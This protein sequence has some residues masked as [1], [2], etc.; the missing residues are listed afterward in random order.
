MPFNDFDVFYRA[1]QAVMN[2][3]DPYSVFG[4]YH[5]YPFFILFLPLAAL[6]LEIAHVVWTL[7]ELVIF[8]AIVRRRA[9]FAMLF[10]P[11]ILAFLMGQIVMPMLAMFALLR[12]QKLQ[13]V[14]LAWL[15][16]KPQ[17]IGLM[18]PFVF[19]RM[20]KNERRGFLWFGGIWFALLSASFLLQPDWVQRWLAVSG[21][22]L[23]AP[24][25]PSV[26]GALS[27]LP[28]P[29]WLALAGAA[30]IGLVVWAYR[31]QDFDILSIVN[32]LVNPVIVSY[33][34]TLLTLFIK[35]W[36][37]WVVLTILSW[38]AFALPSADLWL[39]EG[40]TAVV[41]LAALVYVIREK[42]KK[43]TSRQQTL[44]SHASAM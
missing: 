32:L 28:T 34:L 22:R 10:L 37:M 13:G 15:C 43:L 12:L 26:W 36:R 27:F 24:F 18:L 16:L 39:G 3:Q 31:S 30:T 17:L 19:W 8:V 35:S 44:C 42:W 21:E 6:P 29:V 4:V 33:D 38:L 7:I 14:A 41:T 2:G 40:P 11:V 23:R 20:W 5:P 25:A 9:L 1:A